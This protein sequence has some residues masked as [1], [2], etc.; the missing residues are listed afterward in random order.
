[1]NHWNSSHFCFTKEH[2]WSKWSIIS[3]L[4]LCK[5]MCLI[6]DIFC[7]YIFLHKA[8]SYFTFSWWM[9]LTWFNMLTLFV[10]DFGHFSHKKGFC[11]SWTDKTC[12]FL[13]K[14]WVKV[15]SHCKH[16]NEGI[17]PKW[18]FSWW[19]LSSY[20]LVNDFLHMSHMT[21]DLRCTS[22]VWLLKLRFAVQFVAN[23][24]LK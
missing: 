5:F 16:W 20:G 11:P 4:S 6:K 7:V 19:H 2:Y 22:F 14:A 15:R 21:F 10:N 3:F 12:L 17:I 23:L 13:L 8:H 1:M 18:S 24:A 9:V